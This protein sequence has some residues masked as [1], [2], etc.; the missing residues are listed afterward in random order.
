MNKY[1]PI[2]GG[3][4]NRPTIHLIY[5]IVIGNTDFVNGIRSHVALCTQ[6][7]LNIKRNYNITIYVVKT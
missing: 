5:S 1:N 3:K 7:T 4:Q 2:N 6:S